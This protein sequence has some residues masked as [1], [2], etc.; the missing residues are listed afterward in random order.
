MD[1]TAN[2]L[3][4]KNFVSVN[5]SDSVSEMLGA[6]AKARQ[7]GAVVF[8]DSGNYFGMSSKQAVLHR[9]TD[10]SRLKVEAVVEKKPLVP[11]DAGLQQIA[12]LMVGSDSK[13]LPVSLQGKI[14]GVVFAI[15]V[16]KQIKSI[17]ELKSLSAKDVASLNPVVLQDN[18][19]FGNLV[20][21]MQEKHISK[22]P[23]VNK[24]NTLK[25]IVSFSDLM[26]SYLSVPQKKDGVAMTTRGKSAH[27]IGK[28]QKDMSELPV[29]NWVVENVRTV[30]L[31]DCVSK[32]IDTMLSAKISDV[33]VVEKNKIAGIVTLWDLL[34]CFV[35]L[36]KERKNIQFVNLP[37]LDEIDSQFLN[38]A[39]LDCF[40]KLK[41]VLGQIN[42]FIVHFK[43][44]EHKGLRKKTLV[45]LRLSAPGKFFVASSEGWVLLDVVHDAIKN[46][47]R[48]VF[49]SSKK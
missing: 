42:Y 12:E 45:R 30:S 21:L 28:K 37:E 8:D 43:F 40:D 6:L 24:N 10:F 9:R 32:I 3:L 49:D 31:K 22:V 34:E 4:N 36:K 38:N 17:A 27:D 1:I 2:Q 44:L 29:S 16:V 15:D 18:C 25:G 19:T 47:E 11:A 41:K 13:L 26:E 48:E 39:V 35:R 5:A 23:I 46:L 33:V 14:A 20:S 7:T